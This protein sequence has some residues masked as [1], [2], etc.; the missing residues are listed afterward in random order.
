MN[1]EQVFI[2]NIFIFMDFNMTW[3]F[4]A[5]FNELNLCPRVEHWQDAPKLHHRTRYSNCCY[6][7]QIHMEFLEHLLHQPDI[8]T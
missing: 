8:E 4:L 6:I 2:I 3:N 1:E 7:I 5:D